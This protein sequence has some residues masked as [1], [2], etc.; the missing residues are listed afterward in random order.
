MSKKR[1]K[2]GRR[3]E[4]RNEITQLD[5]IAEVVRHMRLSAT[6]KLRQLEAKPKRKRKQSPKCQSSGQRV[7]AFRLSDVVPAIPL[8]EL[9]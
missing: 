8:A 1:K 6:E 2:L 5:L 4:L 7:P 9:H 3:G